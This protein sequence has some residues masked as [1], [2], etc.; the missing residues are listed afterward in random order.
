MSYIVLARRW[1]PQS[2]DKIIGQQHITTT[3]TNAIITS[4]ISHAYLF[5]GSRGTGKTTTARIMAKSLNCEIGVTPQP[6]N[7]CTS[8]IEID[9]GRSL[10]VM[11]ID[12]ASNRGIDEIRD[13]RERIKF[14]PAKGKYKVYIIDEVH[15]LTEPAF[16]AL[17]KTL[18]E[19][20]AHVI[21]IFAT[22]EQ[23]KVP[24]TILSRCQRFEFRRIKNKEIFDQLKHI[25]EVE[26]LKIGDEI[27]SFISR[28]SMGSMRD[29]E[30][31]L[32]QIVSCGD[33]NGITLKDVRRL[34]GV[35]AQ[36]VLLEFG[37]S[38]LTHNPQ[39]A[40]TLI[41]DLST[42]GV[43]IGQLHL[44]LITHFRNL[45][46]MKIGQPKL[47]E[48]EE[49]VLT[50]LYKQAEKFQLSE[51][52]AIIDQIR[53][54]NEQ[55]RR[56]AIHAKLILEITMI[57]LSTEKSVAQEFN[58]KCPLPQLQ[59]LNILSAPT[60]N[61]K[62]SEVNRLTEKIDLIPSVSELSPTTNFWPEVLL[63][64]KR[65]KPSLASCLEVATV[66]VEDSTAIINLPQNM[67]FHKNTIE[68]DASKRIIEEEIKVVSGKSYI[69]KIVSDSKEPGIIPQSLTTI[70]LEVFGGK[71]IKV[72]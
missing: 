72:A 42:E 71:L 46:M 49:E 18:E 17:L 61:T 3:L 13:L 4:R 24:L 38:I 2:F 28:E 12:G 56:F 21:F 51:L 33:E 23:H 52:L 70:A 65:N 41:D 22:T 54:V 59:K 16:N 34:L 32:D 66:T 25:V 35:P 20:P 40:L 63:R 55:I 27:L 45:I 60:K 44:S 39:K 31:L 37:E 14:V 29:A 19:P 9:T 58:D 11:E 26:G 6:C 50:L 1:R 48:M 57:S 69:I 30:G 62:K 7:K 67:S 10:D 15:M 8:C 64:L 53:G 43:D 5:S 47:V 36:E 68:K